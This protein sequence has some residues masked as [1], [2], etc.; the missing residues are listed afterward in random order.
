MEKRSQRGFTLIELVVTAA[1]GL[2]VMV[3]VLTAATAQQRA[4]HDGQRVRAAQGSARAALSY[5]EQTVARAGVGMDPALA[6][7][8]G[9]YTSGPCPT[10]AV[11]SCPRDASSN[12]DELV[13]YA[14]NPAYYIPPAAGALSGNAWVMV[15]ADATHFTLQAHGAET[16]RKGQILQ[17][18][19]RGGRYYAY[20]TVSTE[21]T[22][23]TSGG[24]TQI[25]LEAPAAVATADPFHRQDLA[26][27]A[28]TNP[29]S[30][31]DCFSAGD[32]RV[33]LIDRFRF[34]VR[35]VLLQTTG[36][37]KVYEPYLVL[38]TGLD[39][40]SPSGVDEGDELLI[41]DGVEIFQVAYG[42]ASGVQV[43][44]SGS[45]AIDLTSSSAVG[46]TVAN[47]ISRT[48]FPGAAPSGSDS[49]YAPSSWYGYAVGPPVPSQRLTN[50]Q[51]NIRT[52]QIGLVVR[53]PQAD[54]KARASLRLDSSFAMMNLATVPAWIR[55]NFA[56]TADD[57]YQRIDITTTIPIPNAV[58]RGMTYF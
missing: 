17:A 6:F 22:A 35:P 48:L 24:S 46:D 34:H 58:I 26:Y 30:G 44:A 28:A 19:C 2:V 32:A 27:C 50:H 25:T 54:T 52:I 11:T 7:D 18:V 45:T 51:A 40:R 1:I 57:G 53:S 36:S 9:W 42:L 12:N 56:A 49:A 41:A 5:L 21:V 38:D 13:F 47:R 14:R 55:D 10:A 8:M 3:G 4:Y 43:G 39:L 16:F 31:C 15:G 37:R 20:G 29:A 33:F 23:A